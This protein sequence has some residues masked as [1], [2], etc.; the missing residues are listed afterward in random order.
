MGNK[1]NRGRQKK[2]EVVIGV[3]LGATNTRIGVVTRDG[4][5]IIKKTIPTCPERGKESVIKRLIDELKELILTLNIKGIKVLAVGIGIAG[6]I[7]IKKGI[8][9][10]SP[11]MPDWRMVPLKRTICRKLKMPVLIENDANAAAIGEWWLGAGKGVRNFVCI[12][13]GTGIGGAL[14]LDGRI[15]HGAEG[16]AGEVGHITVNPNGPFCNCGNKGCLEAYSSATGIIRRAK[17]ALKAGRPSILISIT[18]GD[19]D[20]LTP[21]MVADSAKSGDPLS[22]E[23]IEE[24]GIYL[25]IGLADL[26]N[27]LNMDLVI[28]SGGMLDLWDDLKE[29]VKRT[30]MQRAY[31]IP[32]GRLK[33]RKA[34]LGEMSG[35][36]GSAK[37][38]WN[39]L[40]KVEN[41]YYNNQF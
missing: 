19:Y 37:I 36:L 18:G 22:M 10:F 35:V 29:K 23:I 39:G 30:I 25:G 3:D 13:I 9:A 4:R 17:E 5:I 32:A 34:R 41:L 14:V 11:N 16:M 21:L 7:Y 15:I 38:A 20:K 8:V 28:L 26:V 33:F 1:V 2:R 27:L 40:T 12:T 6:I 31:D 24:A